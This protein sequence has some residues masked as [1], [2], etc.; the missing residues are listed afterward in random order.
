MVALPLLGCGEMRTV[1]GLPS[2]GGGEWER[3]LWLAHGTGRDG[4]RLISSHPHEEM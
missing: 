1:V 3:V 2:D 4:I